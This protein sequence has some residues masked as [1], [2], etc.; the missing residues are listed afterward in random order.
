MLDIAILTPALVALGISFFMTPF[1]KDISHRLGM[2]DRPGGRKKHKGVIARGGGLAI[3]MAFLVS[4]F[5]IEGCFVEMQGLVAGMTLIIVLG[6][7]DDKKSLNP[8]IKLFFQSLAAIIIINS[9]IFID[10]SNILGGR[11][12]GFEYLSYPLT[13]LWIV[14]VT[15]AINIVDGLDGLAA[16]LSTISALTV[17]VVSLIGGNEI[18]AAMAFALGAASLGFLPHNLKSKIFMGDSGSM[19]LGFSLAVLSIV[20]SVK[21]AASFSF[22]VPFMILMV[23]I[24]DTLFAIVRRVK[25]KTSI[26]MGDRRHIH[27]R[28]LDLGFSNKQT[29]LI[30]YLFGLIFSALAIYTTSASNKTGYLSFISSVLLAFLSVFVLVV[31]HQ[32]ME[33][34][35]K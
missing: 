18:V 1:V 32:K 7:M 20:G 19:F 25:N 31:I 30:V 13:F 23:P 28:L 8:F 16:G 5:F 10:I 11:I 34:N 33:K 22:L 14:G 21:L 24:V 12:S 9:G 2:V 4:L 6:I 15:N 35:N 29:I 26:F 3:F 17:G 27:H